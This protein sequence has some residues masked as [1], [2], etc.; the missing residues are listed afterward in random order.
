MRGEERDQHCDYPI[1]LTELEDDP[2]YL[3][4]TRIMARRQSSFVVS[5]H[6]VWSW[7][8][9]ERVPCVIRDFLLC[10]FQYLLDAVVGIAE[11]VLH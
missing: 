4:A 2:H 7:Q 3:Y 11:F 8:G 10:I 9:R 6:R 5:L 1:Q